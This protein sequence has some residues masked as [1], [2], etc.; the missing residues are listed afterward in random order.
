MERTGNL[1]HVQ[2]LLGHETLATV[3]CY[4][5]LSMAELEKA[6]TAIAYKA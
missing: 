1:R 5:A 2:E 6:T 4:T 3:A